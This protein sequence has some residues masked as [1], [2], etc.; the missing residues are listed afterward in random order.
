MQELFI[1]LFKSSIFHLKC[2]QSQRKNATEIP[3]RTLTDHL[4]QKPGWENSLFQAQSNKSTWFLL[5]SFLSSCYKPLPKTK[6]KQKR[7]KKKK[8]KPTLYGKTGETVPAVM[9]RSTWI[10]WTKTVKFLS[11]GIKRFNNEISRFSVILVSYCSNSASSALRGYQ[12]TQAKTKKL[13][14]QE[15]QNCFWFFNHLPHLLSAL[16]S[17]P[18]QLKCRTSQW[19]NCLPVISWTCALSVGTT[20]QLEEKKSIFFLQSCETTR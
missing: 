15:K 2:F 10:H 19:Q 9:I 3:L 13:V 6:N 16:G 18:N 5:N 17:F 20:H 12:N 1:S 7:K 14:K 8:K 4:D 11:L